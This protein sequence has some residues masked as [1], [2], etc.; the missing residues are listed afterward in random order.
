MLVL[1]F[2]IVGLGLFLVPDETT[3][4]WPWQLTPLTS[5]AVGAWLISLGV[6]AAHS[7][8]E[9]D[10]AR[11]R[12][13][14]ATAVAFALLHGVS[15]VRYGEEL[16]WSSPAAFCYVA[17]LAV[18]LILGAWALR[19]RESLSSGQ[20]AATDQDVSD[21]GDVVLG[22]VEQRATDASRSDEPQ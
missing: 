6:A 5:R 8:V 18:L 11:I 2:G 9:D 20:N 7:L 16:D 14:G 4:W 15:L 10:V 19:A 17:V 12:R 22:R 3:S 13:L 21:K 1:I